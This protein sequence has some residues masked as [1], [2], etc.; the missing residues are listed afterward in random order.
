MSVVERVSS[1]VCMQN[2]LMKFLLDTHLLY[3][4]E[5]GAIYGKHDYKTE[6]LTS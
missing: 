3:T 6:G 4:T 2:I 5:R 1:L